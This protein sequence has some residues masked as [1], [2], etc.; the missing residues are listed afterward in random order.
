MLHRQ[1]QKIVTLLI[2]GFLALLAFPLFAQESG[3]ESNGAQER[4]AEITRTVDECIERIR[5][6]YG[7]G[8]YDK[9][10]EEC[11][12]I[13]QLEP[14]NSIA[15]L[16]R[17]LVKEGLSKE[18][19]KQDFEA[20]PEALTTP[21]PYTPDE[22]I[23][24]EETPLF[25]AEETPVV[26]EQTYPPPERSSRSFI[27]ILSEST[28]FKVVLAAVILLFII[29]VFAFIRLRSTS[30]MKARLEEVESRI[31]PSAPSAYTPETERSE[32]ESFEGTGGDEEIAAIV[33]ASEPEEEPAEEKEAI[34]AEEREQEPVSEKEREVE[35]EFAEPEKAEPEAHKEEEPVREPLFTEAAHPEET[36]EETPEETPIASVF[37]PDEDQTPEPETKQPEKGSR[38]E[39]VVTP[40]P[41]TEGE[42]DNDVIEVALPTSEEGKDIAPFNGLDDLMGEDEK[43]EEEILNLEREMEQEA[44]SDFAVEEES[45]ERPGEES[46]AETSQFGQEFDRKVFSD[47]AQEET[48][49]SPE[50]SSEETIIDQKGAQSKDA[51]TEPVDDKKKQTPPSVNNK[52]DEET[53]ILTPDELEEDEL[54][55]TPE[56]GL[57]QE[58]KEEPTEDEHKEGKQ[59]SEKEEEKEEVF[60]QIDLKGLSRVKPAEK[61]EEEDSE[62]SKQEPEKIEQRQERLFQD[63]YSRGCKSIENGDYKKAIHYLTI[64]L[65]LRPEHSD[66]KEKLQTARQKRQEENKKGK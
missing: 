46:T 3:D 2:A 5:G 32:V 11:E 38:E 48:I 15:K 22:E 47:T 9:V 18:N 55:E 56:S 62:S 44:E 51:S 40:V 65:A 59:P 50:I 57:K 42:T 52:A 36:E 58:N 45:Q 41:E 53:I 14:G 24:T 8:Q 33:S 64:A 30:Q 27:S 16:Y 34:S 54:A 43:T 1:K 63:Q 39:I 17:M 20:T 60:E 25:P 29:I 26:S 61:G 31:A 37:E 19:L 66:T 4:E 21:Q 6:Y 12:K 10:I 49:I 13:E 23:A 7:L 35:L 28:I